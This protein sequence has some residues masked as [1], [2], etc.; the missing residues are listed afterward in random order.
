[1]NFNEL[2]T[3]K[4]LRENISGFK[5]LFKIYNFF[6]LFGLKNKKFD[7]MKEEFDDL[8]KKLDEYRKYVTKFNKYFSDEGWIVYDSLNFDFI[9]KAVESFESDGKEETQKLLLDYFSPE[10]IE[11]EIFRLK[12]CKELTDRY[13]FIE[14][15]LTDYKAGRYYSTIPL[16]LM[17]IDGAVSDVVQRGF[18]A[19]S[20]DLN[21]WDAVTSV[22]NGISTV[23]KIFQKTR[24]KTTTEPISFPYRHGILHGKDLSY[25]NYEVAA[26]TWCF[27]FI[28]HDWIRSKS[29]EKTRKVKF[30]EETTP[31][32][33]EELLGRLKSNK[34]IKDKL[35]KWEAR[36]ISEQYIKDINE[37]VALDKFLP[38]YT[39]LVYFNLWLRKNFGHMSNLYSSLWI[40]NPKK[41]AGELR[42]LYNKWDVIRFEFLSID[43]VA[44]AI[45][46]VKAKVYLDNGEYKK[47]R[48][49]LIYETDNGDPLPRNM[50]GATWRIVLKDI[51]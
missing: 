34:E 51:E 25:D 4:D 20:I 47:C 30:I 44:P 14:F 36:R 45:T 21:V 42:E 48:L 49:R 43:D 5:I 11:K 3:F 12:F 31:P 17:V 8:C 38:E 26:K 16:L 22:D 19:E 32:T 15:A 27:L 23:K 37:G 7:E 29:T 28:V 9:K 35:E 39:A 24:K 40:N 6:H 13:R 50:D 33:F 1:M 2:P 46:E 41:Y 18:H 10:N